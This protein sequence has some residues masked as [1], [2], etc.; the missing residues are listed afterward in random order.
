M[1]KKQPTKKS[2]EFIRSSDDMTIKQGVERLLEAYKLRRKFDETSIASVWPQLIGKAIAN[3]TQQLY[4]RDKKNY[5]C[6]WSLLS[7]KTNWH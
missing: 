1:Y 4:V 5:L 3:R 2:L 7:L 6:V